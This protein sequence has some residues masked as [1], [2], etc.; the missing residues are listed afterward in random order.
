MTDPTLHQLTL[1]LRRALAE[2]GRVVKRYAQKGFDI[3]FKGVA[4]VVTTADKES[5][6]II[7]KT[8]RSVFP[9]HGFLMEESGERLSSSPHRWVIDPL[10]G[11]VNFAH[12][13][14]VC[15]V[16]IGV[17]REGEPLVGGV[18][19]PFNGE[20]F[21]AVKGNG[22]TLNGR[23]IHVSKTKK[24]IDSLIA[25]GFPYNRKLGQALYVK[26]VQKFIGTTQGIRRLG[27]A[28]LDMAYVACG[29]FDGY[30]ETNIKPW[31]SAAGRLLVTEAGGTVTDFSGNPYTL[32][33]T[34][35][36]L[37]SNGHLHKKMQQILKH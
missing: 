31:D 2:G 15:C 24:M 25:T 18:F 28:A 21:F 26:N 7:L 34:S 37:A 17:E 8:I 30:W 14:P 6:K 1:V 12:G 29:R 5:E 13:V 23:P 9:H 33:D 32:A 19:N 3:S 36:T 35:Q 27:A 22:A 11:T 4:N 20:L 10:D 16:S